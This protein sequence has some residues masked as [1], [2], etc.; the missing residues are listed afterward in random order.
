MKIS[1]FIAALLV[2]STSAHAQNYGIL[3]GNSLS[4]VPTPMIG[5]SDEL[6]RYVPV[7]NVEIV[8]RKEIVFIQRQVCTTNNVLIQQNI[9]TVESAAANPINVI[10][11][12]LIGAA[13][14]SGISNGS[15]GATAL[16]GAIGAGMIVNSNQNIA[17]HTT[18]TIGYQQQNI[19]QII[20]EPYVRN[21]I[22]G[23]LVTY[24]DNGQ[25]KTIPSLTSPGTHVR[26]VTS[27]RTE[28]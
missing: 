28:L 3:P 10:L 25:R 11:A 14:G 20:E 16:G 8:T 12:T 19:C 26:L 24:E 18:Q 21:V 17:S 5:V 23:Y 4:Y 15:A 2:L 13:I 27:T 22:I 1:K 9:S 6:I 7:V